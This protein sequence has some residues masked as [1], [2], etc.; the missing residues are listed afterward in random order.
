MRNHLKNTLINTKLVTLE[1]E[2]DGSDS[3]IV[4]LAHLLQKANIL[5]SVEVFLH[6]VRDREAQVTT[7]VGWG[8]AIPHARSKAVKRPSICFGRN[9]GFHWK[10]DS[11]ELTRMVFML[12]APENNSDNSYMKMLSLIACKLLEADFREACLQAK[13]ENDICQI[14]N[15]ALSQ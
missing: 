2:A 7:E 1:L 3:A 13:T 6:D 5:E 14:I 12:A 15:D 10:E 8:V 11:P 4:E 9:E